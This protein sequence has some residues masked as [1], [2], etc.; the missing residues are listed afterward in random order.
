[1]MNTLL[2]S[3]SIS[4]I[5]NVY[6]Y[7]VYERRFLCSFNFYD[8]LLLSPLTKP[9]FLWAAY[10]C[11]LFAANYNI[12]LNVENLLLHSIILP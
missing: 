3:Y 5:M 8:L 7:I 11:N 12:L 4:I 6:I 1:M 10:F 9:A 2:I